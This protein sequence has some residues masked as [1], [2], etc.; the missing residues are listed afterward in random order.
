MFDPPL[1]HQF[2]GCSEEGIKVVMTDAKGILERGADG[3]PMHSKVASNIGKI[4]LTLLKNS[5]V[6][7]LLWDAY[8]AQRTGSTS[9]WGQNNITIT[10]LQMGDLINASSVAFEKAPDIVNGEKAGTYTWDFLAG[11]IHST[12]SQNAV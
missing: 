5:P 10:N 7:A 2:C 6:N 3:R 4:T 12:V 1:A 8:N 11:D 9:I